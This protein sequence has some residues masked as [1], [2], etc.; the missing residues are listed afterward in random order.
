MGSHARVCV[1]SFFFKMFLF[2]LK[3]LWNEVDLE[4]DVCVGPDICIKVFVPTPLKV[5]LGLLSYGP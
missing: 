4:S 3:N 1:C 2:I 5:C